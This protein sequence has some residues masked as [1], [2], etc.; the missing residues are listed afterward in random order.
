MARAGA[1][2]LLLAVCVL[3]AAPP[4]PGETQRSA[5]ADLTPAQLA[6]QR[7]VCG[8]AGHRVP[9]TV[10]Q[11]IGRG[12]LAGVILFSNNAGKRPQVR[13]LTASLQAIARPAA[14]RQPLLIAADQEGGQVRR[15]PGPPTAS[16]ESMAA[17]GAAYVER[18]GRRTGRSMAALGVNVDLAPVLDVA[19]RKG[20]IADQQRA[21]GAT[22]PDVAQ[23]GVGFARGLQ[24]AGVAATAK[25]FPGLGSTAANTDL[26]PVIINLSR[27]KLLRIDEAPYPSFIAAGGKLVMVSSAR[28]SALDPI[29]PASQSRKVVTDE[30]RGRLGFAGVTITDALD[31]PG[32]EKLAGT[33][34]TATRVAAAGTD[35]LL[36]SSCSTAAE[37]AAALASALAAGTLPRAEFEAS[38]ERVLGLRA[39]IPSSGTSG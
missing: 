39:A 6:G 15:L 23:F 17:R 25:H 3:I 7:V 10:S 27:A 18:Q 12:E 33:T 32:V 28:Y 8:F 22:P 11:R 20:F 14:L 36:Y 34:K 2:G 21:F 5:L 9:A 29:L 38:V 31:T 4:A 16:A 30:L 13:R 19:R 26:R 35:L 1:A 37:A 24:A